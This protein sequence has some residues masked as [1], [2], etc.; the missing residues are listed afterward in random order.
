MKKIES[1]ALVKHDDRISEELAEK[2]Q[3]ADGEERLS[4]GGHLSCYYLSGTALRS[5]LQYFGLRG[6]RGR[7]V[8]SQ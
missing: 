5:K 1:T 8:S 4:E 2:G 6:K 7:I 3:V